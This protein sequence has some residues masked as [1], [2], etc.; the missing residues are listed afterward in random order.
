MYRFLPELTLIAVRPC[1]PPRTLVISCKRPF[2]LGGI[3]KSC[4]GRVLKVRL[5]G[6]LTS[7]RDL[8]MWKL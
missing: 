7:N 6:L 4:V 8:N 1:H 2:A 3:F 5:K